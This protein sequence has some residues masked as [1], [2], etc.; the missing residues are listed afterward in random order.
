MSAI[1]AAAAAAAPAMT[2]PP[3]RSALPRYSRLCFRNEPPTI[4]LQQ[5]HSALAAG[6]FLQPPSNRMDDAPAAASAAA[7]SAEFTTSRAGISGIER[8]AKKRER[9]I[10]R[11]LEQAFADLDALMANAKTVVDLS[12]RLAAQGARAGGELSTE[13]GRNDLL[14]AMSDMGIANPITKEMAGS[15]YHMQLAREMA[16]FLP[17]LV[18]REGGMLLLTDVY[19]LVNRARGTQLITPM[20]CVT[21]CQLF[22][23]LGGTPLRLKEFDS[24]VK[25]VVADDRTEGNIAQR[26]RTQLQEEEKQADGVNSTVWSAGRTYISVSPLRLSNLWHISI[27]LAKQY[28]FVA[29]QLQVLCRDEST[30]GL[31]FA[32]NHFSDAP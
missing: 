13:Q 10:D 2:N 27:V 20:D 12:H 19:C 4:F 21:A 16:E 30:H 23:Q 5:L 31:C 15:Q 14:S 11:T 18:H 7:A 28:L 22:S 8:E 9:A 32:L 17:N 24:G 1:D 26:I 29:E 25:A 6:V 3:P